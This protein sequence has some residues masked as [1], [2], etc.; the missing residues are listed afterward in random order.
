M[1]ILPSCKMG[2]DMKTKSIKSCA[3]LAVSLTTLVIAHGQ[4][5]QNREPAADR[6][7]IS[8]IRD[9]RKMSRVNKQP[10]DMVDETKLMCAP[11]SM[12]YG[13]HYDPGVVYYVNDIAR[14]AITT[15][16]STRVFPVGSIIVK[17]KQERK[18]EDSVLIITVMK[19]IR[20]GNSEDSWEYK[21]YDT[22]TW[23]EPDG[24]KL[25]ATSA[26]RTCLECHRQYRSND[27]I[28]DKGMALLFGK[29][30]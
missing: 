25:P 18:T 24:S 17:E 19:K 29:R 11:P 6:S 13:P 15:F 5:N 4:N 26:R 12:M 21:M 1:K 23:E 7:A 28:S 22:K 8:Q 2:S 16:P 3:F 27:Y 20:A 10:I 9:Y 30:P 14:D